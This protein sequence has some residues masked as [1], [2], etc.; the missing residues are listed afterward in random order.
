MTPD[1]NATYECAF[2]ADSPAEMFELFKATPESLV[3]EIK[4][5]P[6]PPK[7]LQKLQ[8]L[9]DSPDSSLESIS[10]L[11]GMEPGLSARVVQMANSAH[12][13][14]GAAKVEAP[15]EAL[16]RVGL[17]G[18]KELVTFAVAS[19][20]VGQPLGCYGLDAST[21]WSRSLACALAAGSL[22]ERSG[23]ADYEDSYTAGLLHGLGLVAIDRHA[24]KKKPAWKF[25]SSG[26]PLDFAPAERARYGFSHPAVGAALLELW[27]FSQ[28]LVTAVRFQF[29]PEDAPA[30]RPLCMVLA[31]AR[32]AR[33]L[34]CA[35]DEIIP[36]FP[37]EVWLA[38]SGMTRAELDE[39]LTQVKFRF[40][41]VCME[42]KL[43]A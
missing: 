21:L 31:T 10:K 6:P 19:Q 12:F 26:Y 39:W 14:R 23:V 16:Q 18:V 25:A 11:I 35:A 13:S 42:M 38:E 32:W 37:S 15:M 7:I 29:S 3:R 36:E 33:S 5:L 24:S 9:I 2:C 20:L 41:I 30:H 8:G 1:G 17:K 22:A 28:P 27:G 34:F 40:K 4:D 43:A